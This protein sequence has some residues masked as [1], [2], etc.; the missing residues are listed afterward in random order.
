MRSLYG[1][2]VAGAIALAGLSLYDNRINAETF[3]LDSTVSLSTE[4]W[5]GVLF[6]APGVT[7]IKTL[8]AHSGSGQAVEG[9]CKP[10]SIL[11]LGNSQL[12][13]VNQY[14]QGDHIAPYW[15]RQAVPCPDTT[16]PLGVSLPNA[17]L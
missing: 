3:A 2:L 13:F 6:T 5:K 16:V 8:I 10:L 9:S 11:W 14:A 12:H 1:M 17:N 4:S 15:L 7:E